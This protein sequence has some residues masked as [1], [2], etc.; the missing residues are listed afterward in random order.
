MP[1]APTT[2]IGWAE[3]L[4]AHINQSVTDYTYHA[5][6]VT[7]NENNAGWKSYADCS[8]FVTA[9]LEKTYP[10]INSQY[11]QGWLKTAKPQVIDYF[12]AISNAVNFLPISG[13]EA[14]QAGDLIAI[15][16][17]VDSDP[18]R[19]DTGH[20]MMVRDVPYPGQDSSGAS[21][22][23]LVPIIDQATTG[24]GPHDTRLLVQKPDGALDFYQGLGG[25]VLRL[26]VSNGEG[27]ADPGTIVGY[28]WSDVAKSHYYPVS[29]RPVLIGRPQLVKA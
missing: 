10:W 11:L 24:H 2:A 22:S 19:D 23:W 29:D 25:G 14:A 6:V 8:S 9:L 17:K 16:Y 12:N 7:W 20:L 27:D 5:S 13:L 15:S 4:L 28:A 3:L 18:P 21:Q 26:F 1:P